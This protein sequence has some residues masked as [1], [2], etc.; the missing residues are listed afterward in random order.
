MTRTSDYQKAHYTLLKSKK[1]MFSIGEK[2]EKTKM[3]LNLFSFF[4]IYISAL[5]FFT[6]Y[7]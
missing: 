6:I 2:K 1:R 7:M 3:S 5:L 4:I